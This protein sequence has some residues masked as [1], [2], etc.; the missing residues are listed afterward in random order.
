M[1]CVNQLWLQALSSLN[2]LSA[3]HKQSVFSSSWITEGAVRHPVSR[4]PKGS[5]TPPSYRVPDLLDARLARSQGW[6]RQGWAVLGLVVGI[7]PISKV[8]FASLADQF[9]SFHAPWTARSPHFTA[10]GW[11]AALFL[12]ASEPGCLYE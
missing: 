5:P 1:A 7:L 4:P 9:G 11:A 12:I 6:P 10:I 8:P 3:R 2:L